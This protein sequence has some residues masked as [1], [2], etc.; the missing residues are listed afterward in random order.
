MKSQIAVLTLALLIMA[1]AAISAPRN[2]YNIKADGNNHLYSQVEAN[3]SAKYFTK[4][5]A[6]IYKYW[7]ASTPIRDTEHN[8]K[9]VMT[10]VSPAYMSNAARIDFG[11]IIKLPRR[12][13]CVP[14]NLPVSFAIDFT[15]KNGFIYGFV[16]GNSISCEYY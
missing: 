13:L 5:P 10:A 2:V 1:T 15:I 12:G 11:N 9:L 8:R 4:L 14:S 16:V 6:T 3:A 7:V